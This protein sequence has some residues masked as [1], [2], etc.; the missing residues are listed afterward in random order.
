L[1]KTYY[2]LQEHFTLGFQVS[3]PVQL[4]CS[5]QDGRKLPVT[6]ST[7]G[8]YCMKDPQTRGPWNFIC[9]SSSLRSPQEQPQSIFDAADKSCQGYSV[10]SFYEDDCHL[11]VLQ[12][13][14]SSQQD[15]LP[16][17]TAKKLRTS[18]PYLLEQGHVSATRELYVMIYH[19][20]R[21][22]ITTG[23]NKI[24]SLYCLGHAF[25]YN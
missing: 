4:L 18:S 16:L 23:K 1:E 2:V 7:S 14:L 21:V 13:F 20:P 9:H 19:A 24:S 25:P 22:H 6:Y 12:N 3:D 5:L 17:F 15:R 10:R 8:D 11:C